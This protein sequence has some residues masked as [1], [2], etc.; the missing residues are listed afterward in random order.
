MKDKLLIW[1]LQQGD[2]DALCEI[3]EQYRDDL[4]RLAAGLLND[5]S[6]AEDVVQDVF[7]TL[8][9]SAAQYQI[10]KNLKGY[11]TTAVANKIRNLYR[12]KTVQRPISLDNIEP[13]AANCKT[14]DESAAG[15][16]ESQH[17]YKAIN[18]LPYE[19]KEVLILHIQGRMKFKDIAGLQQTTIKTALSR[20]S[21]GLAKLRSLLNGQVEK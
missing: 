21:Y 20:Y 11:L 5:I 3:Y 12:A 14:P 1:K 2:K 16:E 18:E 6:A 9:R 17:L 4:V 13:T 19:Q 10:S 15:D 8:V 7:L